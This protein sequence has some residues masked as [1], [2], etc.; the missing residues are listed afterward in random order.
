MFREDQNTAAE[1]Y[2]KCS[3]LYL[4]ITW[5]NY[6]VSSVCVTPWRSVLYVSAV[7]TG[8]GLGEQSVRYRQAVCE[9]L[10]SYLESKW[11][12]RLLHGV[13]DYVVLILMH[14]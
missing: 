3:M 13:V 10:R 8:D 14:C 2:A 11:H 12:L 5:L 6:V 4:I 9:S 7:V 1:W